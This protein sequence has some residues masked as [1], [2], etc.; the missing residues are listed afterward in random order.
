MTQLAYITYHGTV[1]LCVD[2]G[3]IEV[4][5]EEYT[6]MTAT[7]TDVSLIVRGFVPCAFLVGIQV[8]KM[9]RECEADS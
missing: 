6:T 4:Y 1:G 3:L 7:E 8:R 5:R 9:F 2:P